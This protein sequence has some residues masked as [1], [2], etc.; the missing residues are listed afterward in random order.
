MTTTETTKTANEG[1]SFARLDPTAIHPDPENRAAPIDKAFATSIATHGVLEPTLVVPHPDIVDA[2]LLVAGERRWRAATT[3]SLDT[4]PAIIN[5]QLSDTERVVR[6]ITENLHRLD[7]DPIA[8]AQQ[9]MR[10][11]TLGMNLKNLAAAVSRSQ[12]VVRDRLRLIELPANAQTLVSNGTWSLDD[13]AHALSLVEHPDALADIVAE[14]RSGIEFRVRRA[15]ADIDNEAAV[16]AIVQAAQSD[17]KTLVTLETAHKPLDAIGITSADHQGEPCHAHIVKVPGFGTPTLV[18]VCT[19]TAR[20]T[21][22]GTSQV[23]A[24]AKPPSSLSDEERER[25]AMAKAADQARSEAIAAVVSGRISKADAWSVILPAYLDAIHADDAK[26]AAAALGIEGDKDTYWP[27]ALISYANE[28]DAAMQRAAF[29][30]AL[31]TA[32]QTLRRGHSDRTGNVPRL[33]QILKATGWKPTQYCKEMIKA[34][35]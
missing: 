4:I 18:E 27:T 29:T 16:T 22:R 9:F 19:D 5:N 28:S 14:G 26:N 25:R 32:N 30:V 1:E 20:H 2:Y 6:Q 35:R 12:R 10:L 13:A 7:L 31:T 21:K 34:L 15:L 24:P 8:E 33:V 23:K 11:S 3:A 17:G